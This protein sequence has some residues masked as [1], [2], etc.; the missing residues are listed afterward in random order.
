M[1]ALGVEDT[2]KGK[3]LQVSLGNF[4]TTFIVDHWANKGGS[5]SIR[6]RKVQGKILEACMA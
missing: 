6:G 4:L 2:G 1:R 3:A 5:A